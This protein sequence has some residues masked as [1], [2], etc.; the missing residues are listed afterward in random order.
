MK[1]TQ[2][3]WED[4]MHKLA[5]EVL[6]QDF[7]EIMIPSI[8]GRMVSEALITQRDQKALNIKYRMGQAL[9]ALDNLGYSIINKGL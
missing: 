8:E 9:I 4:L 7:N 5:I 3:E 2:Q 1:Q 6:V